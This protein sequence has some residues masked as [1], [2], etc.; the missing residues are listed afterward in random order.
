MLLNKK[1]MIEKATLDD[2]LTLEILINSGYRG[3]T[4]KL[5]WTTEAHLLK[6]KRITSNELAKIIINN[7]NTILKY[8]ENEQL[9][10]TV[11]LVNKTTELYLGMLTVLPQIQ[12]K[13]I[14]KR[15]LQE[16]EIHALSLGLPKIVMT[17]ISIRTELIEWYNRNGYTD[18]GK[19]EPFPLNDTDAVIDNQ[20]LTFVVLEKKL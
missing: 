2:V 11:L 12:N 20:Q 13:G 10:G 8:T 14:G 18:T 15:L 16:A 1:N 19:R 17:V 4:S 7:D 6:D 5:G 3:E 9:I